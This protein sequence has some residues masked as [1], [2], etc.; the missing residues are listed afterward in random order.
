MAQFQI[1]LSDNILHDLF[2]NGPEKIRIY[3][4]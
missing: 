2:A 3:S 1:A 4:T